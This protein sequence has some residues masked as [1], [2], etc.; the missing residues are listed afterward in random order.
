M[1]VV[2]GG[3]AGL[4]AARS[5]LQR[6]VATRTSCT[7]KRAAAE[8]ELAARTAAL[9][10]LTADGAAASPDEAELESR[11]ERA[12]TELTAT[13]ERAGAAAELDCVLAGL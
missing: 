4:E 12:R 13:E 2:G 8:L 7:E 11:I 1:V 3:P 9:S 10:A 6:A 5:D